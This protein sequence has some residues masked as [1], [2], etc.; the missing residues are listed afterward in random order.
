MD[1]VP[2][3]AV[4][5]TD[6][7]VLIVRDSSTSAARELSMGNRFP[8]INELIG[9]ALAKMEADGYA[10]VDIRHS[11]VP[12]TDGYEQFA[13]IIGRRLTAAVTPDSLA[14]APV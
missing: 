14:D 8:S 3:M 10:L 13:T 11:A 7:K 5:P 6:V 1:M 12:S 9:D 4:R 2:L